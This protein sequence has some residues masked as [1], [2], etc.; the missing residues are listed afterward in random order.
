MSMG[1]ATKSDAQ[2]A[3]KDR[4]PECGADVTATRAASSKITTAPRAE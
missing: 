3:G 1:T 2:L 4:G